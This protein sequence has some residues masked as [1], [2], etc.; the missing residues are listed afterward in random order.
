M[1]LWSRPWSS[2][3]KLFTYHADGSEYKMGTLVYGTYGD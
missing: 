3:S 1:T 2:A